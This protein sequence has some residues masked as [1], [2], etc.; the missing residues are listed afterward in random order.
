M[1]TADVRDDKPGVQVKVVVYPPD[2]TPPAPG[3]ELQPET[4]VTFILSNTSGDLWSGPYG[5]F[6]QIGT[7]RLMIYADD[8]DGLAAVAPKRYRVPNPHPEYLYRQ[9]CVFLPRQYHCLFLL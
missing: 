1:I 3:Q 4:L 2:Y 7:Y 9:S 6:T 8:K 5:G